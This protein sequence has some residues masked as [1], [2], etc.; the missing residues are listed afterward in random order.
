VSFLTPALSHTEVVLMLFRKRR[1]KC[2]EMK[3]T[4]QRCVAIGTPCGGYDTIRIA[5][6]MATAGGDVRL[7]WQKP[8]TMPAFSTSPEQEAFDYFHKEC[9]RS[10]PGILQDSI[11]MYHVPQ[12]ARTEPAVWHA[13]VALAYIG[14][15]SRS[16][17]TEGNRDALQQYGKA[18]ESL[19][20]ILTNLGKD[21]EKII[22][23]VCLLFVAIGLQL[24]DEEQAKAHLQGGLKIVQEQLE[25]DVP[26]DSLTES[27]VDAFG[28]LDV[29]Y[30]VT[31]WTR[32]KLN[33]GVNLTKDHAAADTLSFHLIGEANRILQLHMAAIRELRY[34]SQSKLL[35]PCGQ[36]YDVFSENKTLQLKQ[37]Q[38]LPRWEAAMQGFASQLITV[39]DRQAVRL[40]QIHYFTCKTMLATCVGGHGSETIFH[41]HTADFE[42]LVATAAIFVTTADL[43]KEGG[44]HHIASFSLDMGFI[45]SLYW[46]AVRC[47]EPSVRH[48]ALSLLRR[49]EHR[50]GTWSGPAAAKAAE[51]IVSWEEKDLVVN[52]ASEVPEVR[53]L[54]NA[55]FLVDGVGR[56]KVT[57]QQRCVEDE[58][59]WIKRSQWIELS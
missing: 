14:R 45:P 23:T 31:Y 34:I 48:K 58:G 35:S 16:G 37:L 19:Q 57:C 15:P 38:I 5:H 8:S 32:P 55:W 4:C 42:K 7:T 30:A 50:E 46:A 9:S 33:R 52:T 29:Q 51:V 20:P 39:K 2:D 22:L 11:W 26:A 44:E 12:L 13:A 54:H 43:A 49:C 3:P 10:L 59:R 40:L 25:S 47:R 41:E 53:R 1:I 27:L 36:S 24:G 6:A 56:V 28:R 17:T 18:M 21:N